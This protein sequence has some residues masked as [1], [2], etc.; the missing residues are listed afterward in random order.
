[1]LIN[2]LFKVHTRWNAAV[3]DTLV[4]GCTDT[5]ISRGVSKEN[6]IIHNVP[7]SFELP[8]AAQKLITSSKSTATPFDACI[9]IGVLIKGST[10]HFEYIADATSHG[11]MNVGLKTD[12]PVIFGVLTCL[13][14]EQAQQRAG[15]SVVAGDN[16]HNHG[17]DWAD[18]ALEMATLQ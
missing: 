8:F 14:E 11:L 6:I 7:G 18:T 4:K 12:T 3:V 5:L 17:I 2:I 1:M 9:A 10:M 15:I 16:A 13:S